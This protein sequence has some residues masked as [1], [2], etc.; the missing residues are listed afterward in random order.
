MD[1]FYE[2]WE[3]IPEFEKYEK[4]GK[5]NFV[6]LFFEVFRFNYDIQNDGKMTSFIQL[7]RGGFKFLMVPL[8]FAG[9]REV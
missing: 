9:N 1:E 8:F 4:V 6:F 3:L 2:Y 5:V 7:A